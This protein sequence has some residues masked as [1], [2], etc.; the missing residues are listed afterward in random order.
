[1]SIAILIVYILNDFLVFPT[2]GVCVTVERRSAAALHVWI[3][4]PGG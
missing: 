1:M 2:S 3:T 4:E